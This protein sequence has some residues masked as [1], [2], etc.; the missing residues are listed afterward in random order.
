MK[1]IEENCCSDASASVDFSMSVFSQRQLTDAQIQEWN[2]DVNRLSS[3]FAAFGNAFLGKKNK[4]NVEC[5]AQH[6]Q[7]TKEWHTN[8][9]KW[10]PM[11]SFSIFVLLQSSYTDWAEKLRWWSRFLLD[12]PSVFFLLLSRNLWL[13]ISVGCEWVCKHTRHRTPYE[14]NGNPKEILIIIS[15]WH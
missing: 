6:N 8:R 2:I 4:T 9:N 10:H 3:Q 5:R 15:N 14:L 12:F 1:I 11:I 13:R 7:I